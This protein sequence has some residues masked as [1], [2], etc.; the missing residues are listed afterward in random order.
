MADFQEQ[1]F[2]QSLKSIL[3]LAININKL[4]PLRVGCRI[5]LPKDLADKNKKA[6]GKKAWKMIKIIPMK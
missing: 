6:C 5:E 4:N 2:G 3:H 1:G